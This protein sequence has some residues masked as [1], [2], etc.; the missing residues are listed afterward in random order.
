MFVNPS[1]ATSHL[2]SIIFFATLLLIFLE[3]FSDLFH[4]V[5]SPS[6]SEALNISKSFLER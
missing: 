5:L 3:E 4:L 6:L 1:L 2:H